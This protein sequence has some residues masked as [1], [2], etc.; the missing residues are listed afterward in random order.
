VSLRSE[1]HHP[2]RVLQKGE[3]LRVDGTQP[4]AVDVRI[5]AATNRVL[6]EAIAAGRF[7]EDLFS[8][9]M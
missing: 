3:V 8:V 7:R 2:L 9:S 4:R 5:V 6:R 1:R